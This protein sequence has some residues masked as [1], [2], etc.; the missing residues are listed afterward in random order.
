MLE[1]AHRSPICLVETIPLLLVPVETRMAPELLPAHTCGTRTLY[2]TQIVL[3]NQVINVPYCVLGKMIVTFFLRVGLALSLTLLARAHFVNAPTA[4]IDSGVVFGT[5]T[6]LPSATAP[7]NKFLGIP[8]ANSPPQRFAPP[9]PIL[10][11]DH[12]INA[13]VWKSACIQ[14][15]PCES[16]AYIQAFRSLTKGRPSSRSLEVV[17]RYATRPSERRLLVSQCVRTFHSIESR[18]AS[19]DV[20]A[21]WRWLAV[22]HE[23]AVAVRWICVCWISRCYHD[24]DQLSHQR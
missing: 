7:V 5:M 13:T 15:F 12:Q 6:L 19:S 23:H 20:L 3:Q 22:R 18:R 21:P 9:Q 2:M 10:G 16:V 4:T 11:H 8:F 24:N 14:A 17:P 1:M